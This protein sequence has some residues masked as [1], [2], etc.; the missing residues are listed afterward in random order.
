MTHRVP[1]Q[2]LSFSDS[3]IL[4][5]CE[6]PSWHLLSALKFRVKTKVLKTNSESSM[7]LA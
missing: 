7:P 6:H 4:L 3:V 1:F 2:P 5:F